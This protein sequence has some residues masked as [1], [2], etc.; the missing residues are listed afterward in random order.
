MRFLTVTTF[1]LTTG[2]SGAVFAQ[3]QKDC[4]I[5]TFSEVL[6]EVDKTTGDK[7]DVAIDELQLAKD[8]F[9]DDDKE[10]CAL[11]LTNAFNVATAQ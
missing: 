2:V 9:L 8:K 3:E 5:G 10:G 6:A 4:D 1:F 11:H 7:R